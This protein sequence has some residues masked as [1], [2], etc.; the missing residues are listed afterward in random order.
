MRVLKYQGKLYRHTNTTD[1]GEYDV[2][3]CLNDHSY[4]IGSVSSLS[5]YDSNNRYI[6]QFYL[7]DLE[8]I[9]V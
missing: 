1:N 8:T 4:I 3:S 9:I 6:S 5:L 7:E 2:Y